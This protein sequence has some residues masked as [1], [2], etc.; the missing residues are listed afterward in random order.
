LDR[1]WNLI[2]K[3]LSLCKTA[4]IFLKKVLSAKKIPLIT[5]D[6]FGEKIP[7]DSEGNIVIR[8]MSADINGKR[9]LTHRKISLTHRSIE[10]R[11]QLADSLKKFLVML[12]I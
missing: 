7:E 11:G 2:K 12:C 4:W 1:K 10:V 8:R 6:L 9:K 5:M 3:Q